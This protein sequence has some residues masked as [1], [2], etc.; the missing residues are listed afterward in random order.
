MTRPLII[1]APFIA[2]VLLAA[3]GWLMSR[4]EYRQGEDER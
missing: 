3:L 4:R 2:A 1:A